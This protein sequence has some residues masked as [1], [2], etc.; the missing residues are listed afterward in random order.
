MPQAEPERSSLQVVGIYYTRLWNVY[1]AD[2]SELLWDADGDGVED[3]CY[4]HLQYCTVCRAVG[5]SLLAIVVF[6]VVYIEK[7]DALWGA[8]T[9]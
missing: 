6:T 3:D 9:G 2:G 1:H 4:T 5:P 7:P 8:L